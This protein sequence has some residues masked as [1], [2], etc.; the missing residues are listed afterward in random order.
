LHCSHAAIAEK[1]GIRRREEGSLPGVEGAGGL[2]DGARCDWRWWGRRLV[3]VATGRKRSRGLQR[4]RVAHGWNYWSGWGESYNPGCLWDEKKL[5]GK[6]VVVAVVAAAP[7]VA[8]AKKKSFTEEREKWCSHHMRWFGGYLRWG[9][10]W[11]DRWWW[12]WWL[13]AIVERERRERAGFRPTLRSIFFSLRSST[14]P[15][16]N[17]NR[18]H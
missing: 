15:L 18:I 16:F 17:S 14:E 3:V 8:V 5:L 1:G 10:W 7:G 11:E 12:W 2:I 13:K 4:R 9:R 6:V